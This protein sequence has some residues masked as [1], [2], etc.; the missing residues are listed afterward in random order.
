MPASPKTKE[1][2]ILHAC[3]AAKRV[4][5]PN[6]SALAREHGVSRW[7][8]RA[9]LNGRQS[10]S[11]RK[12][13]HKTLDDTQEEA[14]IQWIYRIDDL[15]VSPTPKMIENCANSILHRNTPKGQCATRVG[16]A[17]VYR[18]ISRLPTPLQ[19]IKQKPIDKKR[20]D[21]GDIGFQ[22]AWFD[23]LEITMRD[24]PS[25]NIYNFDETGFQRGQGKP[26]KVVT[27]Y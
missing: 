10:L 24:I 17:W 15:G 20:L 8:L 23:R 13:T 12:P 3:Q 6:I 9:R 14:I 7:A 2:R 5:N 27:R 22:A 26:Q 25:Y 11:S 16:N 4:Q 1:D 21:S 19:L 18:F